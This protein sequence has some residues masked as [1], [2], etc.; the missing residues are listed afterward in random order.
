M[1][2]RIRLDAIQLAILAAYGS[3]QHRGARRM[4]MHKQ[5]NQQHPVFLRVPDAQDRLFRLKTIALSS[6]QLELLIYQHG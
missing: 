6:G 1:A 2:E 4:P 5:H 3:I